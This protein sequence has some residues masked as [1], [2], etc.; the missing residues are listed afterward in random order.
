MPLKRGGVEAALERKGFARHEGDHSRFTYYTERDGEWRMRGR[1]RCIGRWAPLR[2]PCC[3]YRPRGVERLSRL[4]VPAGAT[5]QRQ[6][7]GELAV[8]QY[9]ANV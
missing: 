4:P 7:A 2:T 3:A 1:R 6:R 5:L 9:V 8:R